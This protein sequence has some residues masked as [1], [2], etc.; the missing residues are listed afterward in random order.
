M[1]QVIATGKK[2]LNPGREYES[3]IERVQSPWKMLL[4]PMCCR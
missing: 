1:K 3:R 2:L 4:V